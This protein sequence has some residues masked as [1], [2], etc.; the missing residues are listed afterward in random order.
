MKRDNH[1]ESRFSFNPSICPKTYRSATTN[2]AAATSTV[3]IPTT[4]TDLAA[5]TATVVA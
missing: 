4:T 2:L 3:T 1:I 5:A